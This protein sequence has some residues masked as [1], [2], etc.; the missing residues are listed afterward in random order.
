MWACW[1]LDC[2]FHPFNDHFTKDHFTN[3]S[4]KEDS[5]LL[6]RKSPFMIFRCNQLSSSSRSVFPYSKLEYHFHFII[7]SR[8]KFMSYTASWRRV[9]SVWS[10]HFNSSVLARSVHPLPA[11]DLGPGKYTS[12]YRGTQEEWAFSNSGGPSLCMD[13]CVCSLL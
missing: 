6:A 5:C 3:T 13:G 11:M 12:Q 8:L 7:T 10:S 4:Q 1:T 2:V 9:V